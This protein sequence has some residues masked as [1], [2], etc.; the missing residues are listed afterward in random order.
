M[1]RE[2]VHRQDAQPTH[3]TSNLLRTAPRTVSGTARSAFPLASSCACAHSRRQKTCGE[4]QIHYWTIQPIVSVGSN[5]RQ[6]RVRGIKHYYVLQ[7]RK[8]VV[9]LQIE[10]ASTYLLAQQL[11]YNFPRVFMANAELP[12]P[13]HF[14]SNP[15]SSMSDT[16]FLHR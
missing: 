3:V 15:N 7:N 13:N 8:L 1:P 11:V 16:S 14:L 12:V 9:V 4:E 2:H 5:V 10:S 6:K